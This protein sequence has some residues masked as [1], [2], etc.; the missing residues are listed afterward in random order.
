LNKRFK[1]TANFGGDRI[2]GHPGVETFQVPGWG[3]S[4]AG[5]RAR[6]PEFRRRQLT[7][8]AE[9][10]AAAAEKHG[11]RL[12]DHIRGGRR[13]QT[14]GELLRRGMKA[15]DAGSLN[16]SASLTIDLNGFPRGTKTATQHEGLFKEVRLNRGRPMST[17]SET[18]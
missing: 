5:E 6:Y 12:A 10:M 18:S 3:E 16:G 2:A 1:A 13:P 14:D 15:V 4:V 17:A 11:A 8:A 7:E 9:R